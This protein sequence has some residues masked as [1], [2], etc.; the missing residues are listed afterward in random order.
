MSVRNLDKLLKPQSIA[1]IGPTPRPGAVGALVARN[2]RRAGFAGELMFVNPHHHAIEGLSVYPAVAS[3]PHAPDL[4]VVVTPPETV[5]PLIGARSAGREAPSS[6]PLGSANSA[7]KVVHCSRPRSMPRSRI[8]CALLVR[9]ASASWCPKSDSTQH[10]PTWQH[11][12]ETS[13]SS[14]SRAQ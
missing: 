3:L 8:C 10:S 13:L 9:T 2:L 4:A 7:S 5:P 12:P 11:Q 1:L 14:A 6:L